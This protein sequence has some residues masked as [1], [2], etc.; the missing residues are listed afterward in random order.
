L[1]RR[2]CF[3]SD[4]PRG[5]G[6]GLL[7]DHSSGNPRRRC[8]EAV[9]GRVPPQDPGSGGRRP[10]SHAGRSFP[11]A[12]PPA[13]T[14]IKNA[15]HVSQ[16]WMPP[17]C[18]IVWRNAMW[19]PSG[20]RWQARVLPPIK[21]RGHPGCLLTGASSAAWPARKGEPLRRMLHRLALRWGR[22]LTA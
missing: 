10:T 17:T 11:R 4:V 9:P 22:A 14:T 5:S 1:L 20:R 15:Q 18:S 8:A 6:V 3:S 19:A 2:S 16:L 12:L 7:D 21:Q 13:G